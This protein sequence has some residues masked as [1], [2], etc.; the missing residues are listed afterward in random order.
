MRKWEEIDFVGIEFWKVLKKYIGLGL[1]MLDIFCELGFVL[2][3]F[4]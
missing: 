3:V 4:Y 1:L 2:I